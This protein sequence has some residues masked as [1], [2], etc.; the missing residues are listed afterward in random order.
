MG[1]QVSHI[2]GLVSDRI[3]V[4]GRCFSSISDPTDDDLH[5]YGQNRTM[6][7]LGLI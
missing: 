3:I 5:M 6:I 2:I 1:T 7:L 4:Y